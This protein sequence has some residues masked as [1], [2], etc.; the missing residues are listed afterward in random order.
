MT[1]GE[2]TKTCPYCAET[3]KAAAVVC[4]FCGKDLVTP[5]LPSV[6]SDDRV[7]LQQEVA[8]LTGTGWQVVSQSE[9]G[10]QLRKPK[11]WSKAGVLLFVLLP[12]LGAVLYGPLLYLAIGGLVLVAADYLIKK[13][14]TA[15][16]TAEQVG[17]AHQAAR[18]GVA[19]VAPLGSGFA[20]SACGGAVREDAAVCKHCKKQL[21]I[22]AEYYAGKK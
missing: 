4:R 11:E 19:R 22:P 14:R 5:V 9:G 12:I 7:L 15:Y 8:R 17:Q 10:A 2:E 21:Y 3:I 13:E 18:E 6:I 20:C 16:I 1:V